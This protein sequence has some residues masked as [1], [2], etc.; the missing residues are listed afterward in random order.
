MLMV[1]NFKWTLN[2][3]NSIKD[4]GKQCTSFM[5]HQTKLPDDNNING[6]DMKQKQ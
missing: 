6:N 1:I 4:H 3:N 5:V 2:R